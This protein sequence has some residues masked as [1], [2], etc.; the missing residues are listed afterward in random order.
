MNACKYIVF[1]AKKKDFTDVIKATN[2]L[3]LKR[4]NYPRVSEYA[5]Y[6]H[7]P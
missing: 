5:V 2:H 1:M 4:G 7:E 6:S 3:T